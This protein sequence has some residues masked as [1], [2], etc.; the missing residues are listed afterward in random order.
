MTTGTCPDVDQVLRYRAGNLLGSDRQQVEEHLRR[1]PH[2][3]GQTAGPRPAGATATAPAGQTFA[4]L[5]LPAGAPTPGGGS[6]TL[7]V[8]AP[9]GE[10]P[11]DGTPFAG[12]ALWGL[13]PG[14]RL[15]R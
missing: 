8:P 10:C 14:D 12:S 15:G 7:A 3:Q 9:T 6:G 1:C 11:T 13:K 2:C 4:T 5:E